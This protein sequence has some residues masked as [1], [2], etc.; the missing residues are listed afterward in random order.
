MAR[1]KKQ[2]ETVKKAIK[3]YNEQEVYT[4]LEQTEKKWKFVNPNRKLMIKGMVITQDDLE[5]NQKIAQ[6]LISKGLENLICF[7]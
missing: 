5:R 6:Y 4:D 1:R 2:S 7:E 3:E